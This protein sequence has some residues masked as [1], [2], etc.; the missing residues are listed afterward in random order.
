MCLAGGKLET[1][2]KPVSALRLTPD[3][4]ANPVRPE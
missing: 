1:G 4:V 2:F 3:I